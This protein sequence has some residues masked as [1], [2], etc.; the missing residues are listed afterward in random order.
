MVL[1][2]T[3][4][5]A[6]FYETQKVLFPDLTLKQCTDICNA[7][8]KYLKKMIR[9]DEIPTVRFMYFGK[10]EVPRYKAQAI[11]NK[12][13]ERNEKGLVT[14][15]EYTEYKQLLTNFLDENT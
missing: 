2:Q 1:K 9:S 4:L 7:P 13:E 3:D 14:L 6:E 11:L 12:L 5:I 10:F 15:P 8:W